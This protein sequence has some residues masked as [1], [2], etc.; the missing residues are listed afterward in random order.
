MKD[1]ATVLLEQIA[2]TLVSLQPE[3]NINDIV[4]IS[5]DEL[6]TLAPDSFATILSRHLPRFSGDT[7]LHLATR[8][9]RVHA[10][11]LLLA[12]GANVNATKILNEK[13]PLHLAAELGYARLFLLFCNQGTMD[14]NLLDINKENALHIC[15][16]KEFIPGINI[17]LTSTLKRINVYAENNKAAVLIKNIKNDAIRTELEISLFPHQPV[18]NKDS[19]SVFNYLDMGL[20]PNVQDLTG[21]T[22]LHYAAENG[23]ADI[24]LMLLN[25]PDI[26]VNI[27][28]NHGN[29]AMDLAIMNCAKTEFTRLKYQELDKQPKL[30]Y[31]EK[32]RKERLG[33]IKILVNSGQKIQKSNV[34]FILEYVKDKNKKQAIL[35]ALSYVSIHKKS[36]NKT[37]E[38]NAAEKIVAEKI[39]AKKNAEKKNGVFQDSPVVE[40]VKFALESTGIDFSKLNRDFVLDEKVYSERR[41]DQI[42]CQDKIIIEESA[43]YE[44]LW[45]NGWMYQYPGE[46]IDIL[47]EKFFENVIGNIVTNIKNQQSSILALTADEFL[48]ITQ[49]IKKKFSNDNDKEALLKQ[50]CS[51]YA[52]CQGQFQKNRFILRGSALYH[53]TIGLLRMYHPSDIVKTILL[54]TPEFSKNQLLIVH[55]LIKDMLLLMPHFG[56][57][58]QEKNFLEILNIYVHKI[59]LKESIIPFSNIWDTLNRYYTNPVIAPI[60]HNHNKLLSFS[61]K[62]ND[63]IHGISNNLALIALEIDKFTIDLYRQSTLKNAFGEKAVQ[64][65]YQKIYLN[66]VSFIQCSILSQNDLKDCGR[67]YKFWLK[68]AEI[69]LLNSPF[70]PNLCAT[71]IIMGAL[72]C[73]D[74]ERVKPL[75]PL[76]DATQKLLQRMTEITRPNANQVRHRKF[77]EKYPDTFP[78][79]SYISAND[80]QIREAGDSHKLLCF[81]GELYTP[82]IH[83]KHKFECVELE[84]KTN[85]VQEIKHF[86]I[87]EDQLYKMSWVLRPNISDI[88]EADSVGAFNNNL[89]FFKDNRM[90]LTVKDHEKL[91]EGNE[92]LSPIEKW[93]NTLVDRKKIRKEDADKMFLECKNYVETKLQNSPIIKRINEKKTGSL[94][95]KETFSP[96]QNNSLYTWPKSPRLDSITEESSENFT[97]LTR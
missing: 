39:A 80:I 71:S 62:V 35:A 53:E 38:K 49:G 47:N 68:I 78:L 14:V 7:C 8:Y 93:L 91:L 34:M 43:L 15:I 23:Y 58:L 55:I 2:D 4:S 9:Q 21:K 30:D 50:F 19:Q 40:R 70:A 46:E 87:S 83:L 16:R 3:T 73:A 96:R 33:I 11:E 1:K 52:V 94:R 29:T 72:A 44:I 31:I 27:Q 92:A 69:C 37:S 65:S 25:Q 67:A 24:L 26:L 66:M 42:I 79:I 89:K 10:A 95:L 48:L 13:T 45:N 36:F 74:V 5:I 61:K 20:P 54:L 17:L 59:A 88:S 86:E 81:L 6:K 22:M 84:Y 57:D 12:A 60:E 32:I 41:K 85:F 82:I 90:K 77:M 64:D 18:I 28:D 56:Y 75:F 51:V 63:C 76:S 97:S